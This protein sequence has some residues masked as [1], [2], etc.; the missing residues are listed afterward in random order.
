M[1][2]IVKTFMNLAMSFVSISP[3]STAKMPRA[4]VVS[5]HSIVV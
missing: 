1:K 2:I 5:R 4:S 3:T